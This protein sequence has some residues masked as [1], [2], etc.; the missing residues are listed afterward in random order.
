MPSTN[1]SVAA[2][3]SICAGALAGSLLEISEPDRF[4]RHV[5]IAEAGYVRRWLECSNCGAAINVH[6]VGVVRRLTELASG[7]YDV[8]LK[9]SSVSDKYRQVMNMFATSSDNA[10][11][12][13]RIGSFVADWH[14]RDCLKRPTLKVLDIGAGTGVFLSKF[15]SEEAKLDRN[16]EG[17]AFE[18]DEH[19]ATHLRTLKM[20]DVRQSLFSASFGP[21]NFELCTLNKVVEHLLDPVDLIR[22]AG[23]ALAPTTG[24]LY[25][26]VPAKETIF[27]RP[28]NDNILGALHHQLY[29]LSSLDVALRAGGLVPVRLERIYEP[30]GKI[31]IVGFAVRLEAVA[32]LQA[33]GKK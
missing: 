31:S 25:V 5:G 23:T 1:T 17:V 18:P 21:Q 7:Y 19:A 30:S 22:Q 33:R 32:K 24:I 28:S 16:W 12:V 13:K 6:P 11:R 3:C 14:E 8:D 15:I 27:C 20:F 26:E 4:E 29:D 10:M 2:C 9:G